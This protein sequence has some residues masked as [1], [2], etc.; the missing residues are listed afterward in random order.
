M[1]M[2]QI[3]EVELE[4]LALVDEV[5]G[6]CLRDVAN[7]AIITVAQVVFEDFRNGLELII[8]LCERPSLWIVGEV[9]ALY[10]CLL[11]GFDCLGSLVLI[12]EFHPHF[13]GAKASF[14]L[15]LGKH[16]VPGLL[17]SLLLLLGS[18]LLL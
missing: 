18:G 8:F 12:D 15:E 10:R 6:D 4:L 17:N 3:A 1:D 5:F 16:S 11:L 7:M 13:I 2:V 14:L 9:D